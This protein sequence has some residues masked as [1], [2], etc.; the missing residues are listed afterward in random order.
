MTDKRLI[1]ARVFTYGL[2]CFQVLFL[3]ASLPQFIEAENWGG[4]LLMLG[5]T[6]GSVI[7]LVIYPGL[8]KV[9]ARG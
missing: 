1:L 9:M 2:L 7:V 6:A 4:T 5:F 3:A 8:P